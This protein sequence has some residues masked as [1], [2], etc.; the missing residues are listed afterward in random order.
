MA[1]P[2]KARIRLIAGTMSGLAAAL[3]ISAAVFP[4]LGH[5]ASALATFPL[6]V[7]AWMNP[8]AGVAA[9]LVAAFVVL[10]VAP[11]ECPII[12][13]TTGPLGVALGIAGAAGLSCAMKA[14]PTCPKQGF[15][16]NANSVEAEW[17]G[18]LSTGWSASGGC[19]A[20]TNSSEGIPGVW[21]SGHVIGHHT[22][23]RWRIALHKGR[24]R[25]QMGCEAHQLPPVNRAA[26]ARY[27]R[28]RPPKPLRQFTYGAIAPEA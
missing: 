22:P 2:R 11:G 13:T 4:G 12:L 25:S 15:V 7:A 8:G 16:E 20:I 9:Y 14:S 1:R 21:Y 17:G 26:A 18:S 19:S 23:G 10:M 27:A 3:Q 6:A 28:H 5:L 24:T